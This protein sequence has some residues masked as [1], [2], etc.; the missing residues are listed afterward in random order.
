MQQIGGMRTV[1]VMDATDRSERMLWEQG[2]GGD[3]AAFGLIFD[4]YRDRVF[5]H[6]F[7]IL[8][9]V[10]DAEDASAVSFLELWR[11]RRHV[12]L[13][14]GSPLP[15]LL[16][17]TTNTC[18]NLARAKRRYR[19]LLEK[20]PHGTHTPSAEDTALDVLVADGELADALGTLGRVDAELFG[21]VAVEGYSVADAAEVVGISSGA[22]RTRMRACQVVCVSGRCLGARGRARCARGR[23]VRVAR[24][25]SSSLW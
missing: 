20:L 18:R 16:A 10:H 1:Q 9:D 4:L 12:R 3:S 6:A 19:A 14:E 22:A 11:R 5:R 13:V 23:R 2:A 8:H 17:T 7:R 24:G 15:W 25:P 21:L